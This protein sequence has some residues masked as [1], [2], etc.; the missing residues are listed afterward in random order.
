MTADKGGHDEQAPDRYM[1]RDVSDLRVTVG[2]FEER[3]DN[4]KDNMVTKESLANSRLDTAR[5]TLTLVIPIL[6]AALGALAIMF[7]GLVKV[8]VGG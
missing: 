5:W 2:K 1:E 3:I 8:A 7:S 4:I 6:A